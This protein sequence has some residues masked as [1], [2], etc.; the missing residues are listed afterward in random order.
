MQLVQGVCSSPPPHSSRTHTPT[1]TD[2][3]R[4]AL[5]FAPLVRLAGAECSRV[6]LAVC[7]ISVFSGIRIRSIQKELKNFK[8]CVLFVPLRASWIFR[9]SHKLTVSFLVFPYQALKRFQWNLR[10]SHH[11]DFDRPNQFR[12]DSWKSFLLHR[13][14]VSGN[15]TFMKINSID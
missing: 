11:S 12:S 9:E 6:S 8:V 14:P 13:P 4:P 5:R 7:S 1:H 15:R 2:N 10:Q 3:A